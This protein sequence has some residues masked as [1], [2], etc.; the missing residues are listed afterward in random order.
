MT[1]TA[2]GHISSGGPDVA[3]PVCAAVRNS[4][5]VCSDKPRQT[6]QACSLF[7]SVVHLPTTDGR[8]KDCVYI[9]KPDFDANDKQ[10]HVFLFCVLLFNS[11]YDDPLTMVSTK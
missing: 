10:V 11:L 2:F 5:R 8:T 9:D 4:S 6:Y 1:I 3:P 7:D